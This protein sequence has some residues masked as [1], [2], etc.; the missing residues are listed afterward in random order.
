M[1][2][3]SVFYLSSSVFPC[4]YDS[5]VAPYSLVYHFGA[6]GAVGPLENHFHRNMVSSDRK[7]TTM[8]GGYGQPLIQAGPRNEDKDACLFRESNFGRPAGSQSHFSLSC[9][10][11]W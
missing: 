7:L 11:F 10:N 8:S 2:L 4:Q 6:G 1:A 9:P 3:G 5:T